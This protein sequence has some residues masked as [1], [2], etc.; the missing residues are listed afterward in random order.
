VLAALAGGSRL[1]DSDGIGIGA[2]PAK[3]ALLW[4][5][6][7]VGPAPLLAGEPADPIVFVGG[8]LSDEQIIV[9]TVTVAAGRAADVALLDSSQ[10]SAANRAFLT[11]FRPQQIIPVGAFP[12]GTESLQRRLGMPPE[13]VAEW[14]EGWPTALWK[15]VFPKADRVVVCPAQPRGL[16][17][18]AACLAGVLRAPLVVRHGGA[19]EDAELVRQLTAWGTREVHIA[20]PI[21]VPDSARVALRRI[22]LADEEAVRTAYQHR[23]WRAGTIRT[24]VIANAADDGKDLGGMSVLAPAIAVMHRA[25]LLLTNVAGDNTAAL[26]Q[27]AIQ[28]RE[29]GRIES[30]LLVAGLRAIPME[31]RPNPVPGK[32]AFIEMEPL[33]PTGE[34]PFSFATGRMFHQDRSLVA[35]IL[36]RQQCLL[37]SH[38]PRQALLVSNPGDSLPLLE[39]FSRNTA[40]ELRNAGYHTTA[41]FR[42]DSNKDLVRRLLPDQDIF[43]WEGHHQTLVRDYGLPAWTERL[44]PMLIVLQ[45][46]LA[47]NEPETRPLFRRGAVAV[48]GSSTRTYSASGGSFTMAFFDG[49][50]YEDQSLGGALRQAKN[51]LLAYSLL[52]RRRLGDSA[53]LTGANLRSAWA[54]SLWGDPTLKLP[55]PEPPPDALTAVEHH[56]HGNTIVVTLPE[57]SYEKVING[58]YHAHMAPNARLAGLLTKENE[59]NRR[60]VPFVFAEVHLP[61]AP[62]GARPQL[63]GRLSQRNWVF[64][65]D[66]RRH[67]GYLLVTPRPGD[68]REIRFH[69]DW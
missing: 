16:L 13:P 29:L 59:D 19:D 65:W 30:L 4:F 47:L 45:S 12:E 56:V 36:A 38:V 64:T 46:C 20:G 63:H 69:V 49:L 34:E 58:D 23:L 31:H 62:A 33:T 6:F 39:T 21:Q 18:Q 44:C 7:L 68:Q 66:A 26:V 40:L 43:L 8:E 61:R 25:V 50:L 3:R 9:F 55:R 57:Q 48:V 1:N 32:D 5:V 22:P 41:L 52:K 60:F 14:K 10:A 35:L 15:I 24:L 37:G 17:L 2:M 54:F 67:V 27:A 51:F 11:A 42:D 28:E 53:K